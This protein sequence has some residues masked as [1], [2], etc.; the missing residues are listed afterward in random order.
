MSTSRIWRWSSVVVAYG[1]AI[2]S[3]TLALT[4]ALLLDR[5]LQTMP[6]VSLLLCVA[7][8]WFWIAFERIQM[9]EN[10][11]WTFTPKGWGFW[12][13]EDGTPIGW[14]HLGWVVLVTLALPVSL[15]ARISFS[16][17]TKS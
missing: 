12:V 5:Y 17:I 11:V 4:M 8:C 16:R 6:Y 14:V 15:A 13:A 3:V 2:L 1:V 9:S 10:P 7:V